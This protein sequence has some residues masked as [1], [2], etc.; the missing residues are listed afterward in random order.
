MAT[1]APFDA[2]V[3]SSRSHSQFVDSAHGIPKRLVDSP[4]QLWR[5]TDSAT[6]K[7]QAVSRFAARAKS[8]PGF[9]PA[10]AELADPNAPGRWT[11]GLGRHEGVE[12]G[13]AT[14]MCMSCMWVVAKERV[15]LFTILQWPILLGVQRW[16]FHSF[17]VREP[18]LKE[19]QQ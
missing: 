4:L 17:Q 16:G 7:S 10:W 14:G 15:F 3:L 1:F 12:H 11:G 18:F 6:P 13:G 19:G 2:N 9:P 5:R 8:G